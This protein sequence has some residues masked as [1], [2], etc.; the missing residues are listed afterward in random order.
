MI[1]MVQ[2]L[3]QYVRMPIHHY[4]NMFQ[5]KVEFEEQYVGARDLEVTRKLNPELKSFKQWLAESGSKIPVP[6]KA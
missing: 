1:C 3:S 4:N 2:S 5:F 6:E